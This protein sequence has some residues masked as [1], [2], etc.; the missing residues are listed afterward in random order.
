MRIFRTLFIL[1]LLGLLIS[2]GGST[3]SQSNPDPI[4]AP[5]PA[6]PPPPPSPPPGG[7]GGTSN[8]VL[9]A[10][11]LVIVIF[12]NQNYSEVIGSPVM[13]FF[14][15]FAQQNSLATQFYANVHPSIGNYFM[16]TTGQVVTEDDTFA[17]TFA[18]DNIASLLT[19]AGKTWKVYAESLPSTGYIGGDKNPY[20]KRHNPFAY[21]DTVINDPEQRKNI[22]DFS[23]F[24]S[25]VASNTL[26]NYSFVVPN[27][28]SNGHDCPDG[29]RTCPNDERLRSIENW[30]KSNFEPVLNNSSVI[31]NTILVVTFDESADDNTNGG[32]LIPF[33]LAGSNVKK[34]YTSTT[35]Y[36]F[37]S[38][39]RMSMEALGVTSNIPGAAASAPSMNEFAK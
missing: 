14:N 8:P 29:S 28:R 23:Q 12:E 17:G 13:P 25:D 11:H 6:P 1:F 15:S 31:S 21:F 35:L 10:Q 19:A 7:G 24:T 26:P 18:G 2:C 9:A 16:M 37:P 38:L 5:P 33:I 22:V 39:L 30:F 27:N 4:P 32:G 34:A 3:G 36:Q 20:V